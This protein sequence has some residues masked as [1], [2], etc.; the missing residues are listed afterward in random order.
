MRA[1]GHADIVAVARVLLACPMRN[2]AHLCR[3]IM[4]QAH[5]ADK[6]VA[7]LARPH[8]VWGNG[9]LSACAQAHPR[10]DTPWVGAFEY[11]QCLQ[12]V[13][14]EVITRSWSSV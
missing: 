11:A 10:A 1:I 9:T 7:R 14:A 5:C 12:I 8:P 3:T 13:L 6:Y 4:W 2:R